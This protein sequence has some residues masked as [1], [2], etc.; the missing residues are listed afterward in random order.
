MCE[1]GGYEE[2]KSS[3]T[4]NKTVQTAQ[5]KVRHL[6]P[7]D[8]MLSTAHLESEPIRVIIDYVDSPPDA[9]TPLTPTKKSCLG[10]DEDLQ[11]ALLVSSP[12]HDSPY[13]ISSIS[14]IEDELTC[15]S[16]NNPIFTVE[17]E[18]LSSIGLCNDHKVARNEE[19]VNCISRHCS[20]SKKSKFKKLCEHPT[21][22]IRDY[23][24]LNN[25]NHIQDNKSHSSEVKSR[26]SNGN[27]EDK[28]TECTWTCGTKMFS[29][30]EKV[31]QCF[32]YI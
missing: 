31:I 15:K 24:K 32:Q 11:K 23:F 22:H 30:S 18:T 1:D 21:N 20:K 14:T 25:K 6:R 29:K 17:T 27:N 16:C 4:Q 12:M 7:F 19:L 2:T 9:I 13:P 10:K 8:P 26:N 28:T 3:F 5:T